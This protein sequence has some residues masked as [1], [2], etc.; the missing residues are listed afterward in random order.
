MPTTT[1]S[2]TVSGDGAAEVEVERDGGT[3][4]PRVVNPGQTHNFVLDHDS[5]DALHI[6]PVPAA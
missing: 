2:V 1:V 4:E 6:R 5:E 3:D